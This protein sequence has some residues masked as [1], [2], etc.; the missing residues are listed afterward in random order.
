MHSLLS[1]EFASDNNWACLRC[2]FLNHG[3]LPICE[4]CDSPKDQPI[5]FYS[6]KPKNTLL[7]ENGEDI[8]NG[9]SQ[10]LAGSVI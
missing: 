1:M 4:V 9:I 10:R 5:N 7:L 6:T 2:T 3:L 8:V